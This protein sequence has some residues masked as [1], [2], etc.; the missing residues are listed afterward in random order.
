VA[1]NVMQSVVIL[2]LK[3]GS[4]VARSTMRPQRPI[5]SQQT[6]LIPSADKIL[7]WHLVVYIGRRRDHPKVA[8]QH[9]VAQFVSELE[10][11]YQTV[12]Q[13][14]IPRFPAMA[15]KTLMQ[16]RNRVDQG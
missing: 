16:S 4:V 13:L 7:K 15:I 1:S 11:L 8:P 10:T 9:A 5:A 14:L 12:T 2:T 6:L 3:A